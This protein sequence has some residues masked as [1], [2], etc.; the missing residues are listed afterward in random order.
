MKIIKQT[1][2]STTK[3]GTIEE[4]LQDQFTKAEKTCGELSLLIQSQ[5]GLMFGTL[6]QFTNEPSKEVFCY[7]CELCHSIDSLYE[8]FNTANA[9]QVTIENSLE[10]IKAN[11]EAQKSEN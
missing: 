3:M 5:F 8:A 11:K 9:M 7:I 6:E 2:E 4:L 1:P 10:K